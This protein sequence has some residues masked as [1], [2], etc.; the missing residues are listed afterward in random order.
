MKT[1][2]VPLTKNKNLSDSDITND[3]LDTSFDY[4]ESEFA[5]LHY[6][7]YVPSTLV[8]PS[9]TSQKPHSCP[10]VYSQVD[11]SRVLILT[12]FMILEHNPF[13]HVPLIHQIN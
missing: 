13:I 10:N 4:V 1:S 6:P 12:L 3:T 8:A 7:V 11:G 9:H 5:M 2:L